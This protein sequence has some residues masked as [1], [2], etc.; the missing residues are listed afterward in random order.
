M[1]T[2]Y[3]VSMAEKF[4]F[5]QTNQLVHTVPYHSRSVGYSMQYLLLLMQLGDIMAILLGGE[6]LKH[7]LSWAIFSHHPLSLRCGPYR[8]MAEDPL[9]FC[10]RKQTLRC[11]SSSPYICGFVWGRVGAYLSLLQGQMKCNQIYGGIY[12][13]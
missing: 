7:P 12:Q 13:H 10:Q 5:S 6:S 9:D 1:I 8:D 11:S 3:S 2:S 4:P